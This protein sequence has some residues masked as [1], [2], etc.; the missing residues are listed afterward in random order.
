MKTVLV[1]LCFVA[2]STISWAQTHTIYVSLNRSD[3]PSSLLCYEDVGDALELATRETVIH[4]LA[5]LIFPGEYSLNRSITFI[6]TN[7]I[8]IA[9]YFPNSP[10]VNINCEGNNS[11]LTFINS[12][13]IA[14]SGLAFRY[15]GAIHNSTSTLVVED[16][17]VNG[18]IEF[19]AVIYIA[20]CT[21]FD[22]INNTVYRSTGIAVQLYAVAGINTISYNV[23]KENPYPHDARKG[24][25][26]YIE[27]LYCSPFDFASCG[28]DKLIPGMTVSSA[29]Y[30]IT[31]NTFKQN[32]ATD[33]YDGAV[34]IFPNKTT[35]DAFGRGGGLSL[36]LK[37]NS[38][39]NTFQIESNTFIEN[40]ASFGG[41]MLVEFQDNAS[42][43]NVTVSYCEFISNTAL[44]AGGGT[45]LSM[46]IVDGSI[47]HNDVQFM[48]NYY[49][50]NTAE[51]GGGVSVE[52]TK[53]KHTLYPTNHINF[54]SSQWNGNVARLGS[55]I[56]ITRSHASVEDIGVSINIEINA[57]EFTKN[58]VERANDVHVLGYGAVYADSVPITFT[59]FV[60][61][62]GNYDGAALV[63]TDNTVTF[64]E[65]CQALFVENKGRDGPG[66]TIFAFSTLVIG[67][68]TTLNFTHNEATN[69]GGAIFAF[70]AGGRN[71][72]SSRDCFLRYFDPTI[73]PDDWETDLI[74]NHNTA[75]GVDNA[76][77]TTSVYPC[78]WGKENGP[79]EKNQTRKLIR[80][81]FCWRRFHYEPGNCSDKI[82]TDPASLDV[83][84]TVLNIVPGKR[85]SLGIKAKNDRYDD[86]SNF[87]VLSAHT[88]LHNGSEI[89]VDKRSKYISS[90]TVL[91]SKIGGSPDIHNTTLVLE[92]DGPRVIKTN[93]E[94]HFLPCP[95]GF[96]LKTEDDGSSVC[97]CAP[98]K[99]FHGFVDCDPVKFEISIM[100]GFWIGN[101]KEGKQRVGECKY[102]IS[103]S[104]RHRSHV[105]LTGNNTQIEDFL[106]ST[107]RKGVLCSKCKSGYSPAINTYEY[108]CV[109]CRKS[110]ATAWILYIVLRVIFPFSLFLI[111][112]VSRFSV[113]SGFLNG[114]IFFAQIISSVTIED[115]NHTYG[116]G[117]RNII[118][119]IY[120]TLYGFWN[121]D[122]CISCFDTPC[123]HPRLQ[124]I[125]LLLLD[126]IIAFLPLILVFFLK[127]LD[128]LKYYEYK[129][130]CTTFIYN[131][132]F[133]S[134]L[135]SLLTDQ[136]FIQNGIVAS[137][138][139]AYNKVAVL[140]GYLL[141]PTILYGPSD[142]GI[143][144][145]KQRVL[146]FDG[147][148]E[149][150][151]LKHLSFA[152]PV[153]ILSTVF[154]LGIPL[155]LIVFRYDNP[156]KNG[157][158]FNH[159]FKLFQQEFRSDMSQNDDENQLQNVSSNNRTY[160]DT[161][162]ANSRNE[163]HLQNKA[164]N[165]KIIF[166]NCCKYDD[167]IE[168]ERTYRLFPPSFSYKLRMSHGR[169]RIYTTWS[170]KE[171]R[172]VSGLYLLLRMFFVL[173]YM[174]SDTSMVQLNLQIIVSVVAAHFFFAFR[175][176]SRSLYNTIDGTIFLLLALI[177]S[178]GAY[179]YYNS[180]TNLQNTVFVTI[181]QSAMILS[182]L[183]WIT[184]YIVCK[185]VKPY[186][187][188][189][190][191]KCCCCCRKHQKI[192]N[193]S[194]TGS[195]ISSVS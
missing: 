64:A 194:E 96:F 20:F 36:Y 166:C 89:F 146:Y 176:Y 16:E 118:E 61:F 136:N 35:H 74:F 159:L 168:V 101:N 85:E 147:S 76:I 7:R 14:I 117:T 24:G 80:N 193:S 37:G 69:E 137:I 94:I 185:I 135:I 155:L 78:L 162:L 71:L 106:C 46:F 86:V 145:V 128:W 23:F 191:M 169:I 125:H 43:N 175:P 123:L 3:C 102:C 140:T 68:N 87:L 5:V 13:N 93:L 127:V 25:G 55:A 72:L 10:K 142:D 177:L 170:H 9:R 11:G 63:V 153:L 148:I 138:I 139:L 112:F 121:L 172:W 66:I 119:K 59:D 131:P 29:Q 108:N 50:N 2:I 92:S 47:V 21:N 160:R 122:F 156:N 84:K 152:I 22:L 110:T 161:E 32:N 192:N 188:Q 30:T 173:T 56:D 171:F 34:F 49:Y 42:H 107:T 28:T 143:S 151:G 54:S 51:V 77:F 95:F 98:T 179:Q 167:M 19:N 39:Y 181:M 141:S 187:K 45:R 126:Y 124:G 104:N 158:F 113:A 183:V 73:A 105:N 17:E 15:C 184:G 62:I 129:P 91:L 8:R 178:L 60:R 58:S 41:G 40:Y 57:C 116:S 75:N 165:P 33:E 111:L 70:R 103:D 114:P 88:Y 180:A 195:L 97:S 130:A 144:V 79:S 150:N 67:K 90:G 149:F 163:N 164:Y 83:N 115:L 189:I 154:L 120:H 26:L 12:S 109:E 190:R 82:T 81:V 6:A 52:I 99:A 100:K 31:N 134:R 174:F 65:N 182:P 18:Y 44:K 1:V 27:F 157:G 4:E 38:S 48:Q 133:K 132:L 186:A 53:E